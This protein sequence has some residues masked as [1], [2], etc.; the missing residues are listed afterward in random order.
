MSFHF[1]IECSLIDLPK[2]YD[3]YKSPLI[4]GPLIC[5]WLSKSI[6]VNIS[7][8]H[9]RMPCFDPVNALIVL[10]FCSLMFRTMVGSEPFPFCDAAISWVFLELGIVK[11][12][13]WNLLLLEIL[14]KCVL[15][16]GFF[17]V[18]FYLLWS[19]SLGARECSFYRKNMLAPR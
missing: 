19:V 7:G 10:L 4:Y 2:M 9:C 13:L 11:F 1:N 8:K 16:F 5:L 18:E 14:C 12:F 3:L 15:Q 17:M 6:A